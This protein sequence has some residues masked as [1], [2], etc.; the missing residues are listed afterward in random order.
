M[1]S[2]F[3]GRW[4][5]QCIAVFHAF[6]DMLIGRELLCLDASLQGVLS[7]IK[8]YFAFVL[9]LSRL[10]SVNVFSARHSR[11]TGALKVNT[12][13]VQ[14]L[15]K[16]RVSQIHSWKGRTT[17]NED[18]DSWYCVNAGGAGAGVVTGGLGDMQM[19]SPSIGPFACW[20]ADPGGIWVS[21]LDRM[22]ERLKFE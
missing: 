11:G 10:G 19:S 8:L 1:S 13:K 2:S 18:G 9:F 12:S 16:A 20:N 15:S 21:G 14:G 22:V 7:D 6:Y 3:C 17:K 4:Y 5:H